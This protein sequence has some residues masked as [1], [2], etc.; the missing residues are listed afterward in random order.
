MSLLARLCLD[1]LEW[2]VYELLTFVALGNERSS[3]LASLHPLVQVGLDYTLRLPLVFLCLLVA[4]ELKVLFNG[5]FEVSLFVVVQ[6]DHL[7]SLFNRIQC[8]VVDAICS[9]ESLLHL[10]ID[11]VVV[12]K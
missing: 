2:L 1:V 10:H 4:S 7:A 5:L 12:G 6:L 8:L 9:L 3:F 11:F